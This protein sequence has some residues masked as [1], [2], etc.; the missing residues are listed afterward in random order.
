MKTNGLVVGIISASLLL[1]GCST[2]INK[3]QSGAA[4]GALLGAALG[5]GLGK[6]HK[7]KNLAVM[8]GAAF[9]AVA[10]DQIGAQL[11]EKDRLLAG[12][13]L[14][15]SLE[16]TTDGTT[17]TW[18]NPNTGHSGSTSP[19]KSVVASDGTPCREFTTEIVVGGET[20]QGYGTACRQADGSWKSM[21]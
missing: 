19:T 13:N 2:T 3:Q 15:D 12:E 5:Y 14:Q 6:G 7:H 8:L 1:G 20:H 11:D 18:N 4:A 9:G 16:G 10:G 17:S 21:N